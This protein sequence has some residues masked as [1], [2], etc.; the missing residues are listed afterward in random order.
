MREQLIE[1]AR[2]ISGEFYLQ[3]EFSAGGVGAAIL[4][5]DGNIYSGIC[6]DLGCGLGFCAEVAAM[7]E[8]LKHRETHIDTVVAVS[9]RGI[10]PPCGRCRETMAQLDARNLDAKVIISENRTLLLRDLLPDHWLSKPG[11]EPSDPDDA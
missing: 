5:A 2:A 6:L 3:K 7:A 10:L 8:M 1:T 9:G 11:A 4:T